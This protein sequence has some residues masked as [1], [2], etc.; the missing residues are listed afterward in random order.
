[1]AERS[2]TVMNTLL[3]VHHEQD[4]QALL[5]FLLTQMAPE[6]GRAVACCYLLNDAS[7]ETI[8]RLWRAD[9]RA[10]QAFPAAVAIPPLAAMIATGAP[11][12]VSESM[13]GLLVELWGEDVSR[14]VH[15]LLEPRFAT[16]APIATPDGPAGLLALLV[17]DA[18]PFDVAAECTAHAAAALANLVLRATV[19]AAVVSERDPA[20]GLVTR[21]V[22]DR[23]GAREL[24]RADR[25][26]R[27]LSV[28]VIE[29]E[30]PA[31]SD[32]QLRTLAQHVLRVMRT[33]DT[34]GRL[35]HRQIAVIL[36]ETPAG[37]ALAFIRRLGELA[38]EGVP[39][40]KGRAATF[41]QDGKTWDV[42]VAK[43]VEK[44]S[45]PEIPTV[46]NASLRGTLRAAMPNFSGGSP[47]NGDHGRALMRRW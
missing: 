16:I 15:G 25:Y 37:G 34:A 24:N 17:L 10:P 31:I 35:A 42:L 39:A 11:V 41:P 36:P 45:R 32:E 29:P 28:A 21:E 23:A 33:P 40:H 27:A 4:P 13:P 30:D 12:H 43:A 3:G 14:A 5:R 6:Y 47:I 20:T 46:P 9:V 1:M 2:F 19:A 38:K 7:G 18:W 26:R 44:L 22:L 8:R